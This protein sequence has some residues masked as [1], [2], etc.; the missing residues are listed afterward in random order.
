MT[1]TFVEGCSSKQETFLPSNTK[2]LQ[3]TTYPSSKATPNKTLTPN[4][5]SLSPTSLTSTTKP[6]NQLSYTPMIKST[7]TSTINPTPLTTLTPLPTIPPGELQFYLQNLLL[8]NGGCRLPCWW[9]I[10]P[11]ITKWETARQFL[12]SFDSVIFHNEKLSEIYSVE[13]GIVQQGSYYGSAEYYVKDGIII[14]I[15]VDS[16]RTLLGYQLNKALQ[17]YG[18][19]DEITIFTYPDYLSHGQLPF[20]IQLKYLND[21]FTTLYIFD[22]EKVGENIQ[23][24]PNKQSKGPWIFLG[25]PRDPAEIL[26]FPYQPIG[27]TT[28]ISVTD[29]YQ[30]YLDSNSIFCFSTPA[31]IWV[32]AP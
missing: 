27:T 21:K 9:G 12:E 29:F 13:Y 5:T 30:T 11:G 25:E 4:S 31:G 10:Y 19:P 6:L 8:N 22:A 2:N 18:E 32:A 15:V 26:I 17:N 23:V 3:R 16:T 14:S 24:C 20:Y 28:E 7:Q 1:I